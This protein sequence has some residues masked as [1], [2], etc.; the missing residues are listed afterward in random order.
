MGEVRETQHH[1]AVAGGK[2]YLTDERLHEST[3][4]YERCGRMLECL[5]QALSKWKDTTRTGRAVREERSPHSADTEQCGWDQA[6]A[7]TEDTMLSEDEHLSP[8]T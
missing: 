8:S 5:Q 6:V 1:L 4:A 2:G 3:D 7:I